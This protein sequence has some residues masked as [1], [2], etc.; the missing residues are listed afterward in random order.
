MRLGH[1]GFVSLRCQSENIS[2]LDIEIY[3]S[4]S[5]VG[6]LNSG[7]ISGKVAERGGARGLYQKE[8]CN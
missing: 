1:Y 6:N 2:Q 5:R 4:E 3:S 8:L 7:D